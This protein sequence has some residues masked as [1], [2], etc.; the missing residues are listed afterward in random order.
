MD[1]SGFSDIFPNAV[2]MF[3]FD[4]VLIVYVGHTLCNSNINIRLF[5]QGVTLK[6]QN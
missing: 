6:S 2:A 4:I 3:F 1:T 5:T